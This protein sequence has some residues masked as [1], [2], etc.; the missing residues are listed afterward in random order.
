MSN[1]IEVTEA[2][3]EPDPRFPGGVVRLIVTDMLVD[4]LRKG[5]VIYTQAPT[6]QYECDGDYRYLVRFQNGEEK[7]RLVRPSK[8]E[9]AITLCWFQ[10]GGK[11]QANPVANA[12]RGG[13]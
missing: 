6:K 9:N 2:P 8:V 12:R 10:K 3:L 7:I 11:R 4:A 5:D 13:C 1:L